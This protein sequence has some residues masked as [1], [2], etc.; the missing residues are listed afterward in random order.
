MSVRWLCRKLRQVGE[1][2]LG[3]HGMY[4]PQASL[5]HVTRVTALGELIASIA[6]EVNQPLAAIVTNGDASLRWLNCLA[7]ATSY[8]FTLTAFFVGLWPFQRNNPQSAASRPCRNG[9]E[10]T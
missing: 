2:T 5:A 10:A 3:R 4:L 9:P 7:A 6:H 8:G 1:G